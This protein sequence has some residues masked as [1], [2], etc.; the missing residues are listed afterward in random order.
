ME[1]VTRH[2]AFINVYIL[3]QNAVKT[4]NQKNVFIHRS[5]QAG[6]TKGKGP[7]A[8]SRSRGLCSRYVLRAAVDPP[9]IKPPRA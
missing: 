5:A 1:K 4:G 6:I 8:K 9:S 3:N 7:L 2:A